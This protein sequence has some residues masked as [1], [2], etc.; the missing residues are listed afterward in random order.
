MNESVARVF[1]RILRGLGLKTLN[2]QF[3]LSYALM[4]GL[5]ACAS[6]ALYLSMSISP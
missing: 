5:A 2:A 1:D 6:V 4:F 3:L